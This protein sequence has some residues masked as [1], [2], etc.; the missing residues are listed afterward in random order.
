[1][2]GRE[3]IS[4]PLSDGP[5]ATPR[6]A[7]T[8]HTPRKLICGA[9]LL[10]MLSGGALGVPVALGHGGPGQAKQ[11]QGPT[12]GNGPNGDGPPGQLR[13]QDNAAG[14]ASG[15]GGVSTP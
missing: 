6:K 10:A 14:A 13:K 9:V 11:G 3:G 1:M 4:G 8:R 2:F 5:N 15:P 7:A 12:W